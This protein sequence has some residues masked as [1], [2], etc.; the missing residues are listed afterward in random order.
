MSLFTRIVRDRP[1]A[2]FAVLAC[3]LGWSIY[4][5]SWFGAGSNPDNMP[6]GPAMAAFIV[7][8]VQGREALRGWWHRIRN[9]RAAPGWYAVAFLAPAVLHV[10]NVLV[11][12]AFGAPLPTAAQL[13]AWPDVVTG[14]VLMIIAVGIGEEAGWT[15]FAAPMLMRR[16]GI[17]GAWALLSAVRIAWHL[18]LMLSGDLPWLM[19]IVGNAAFQMVLL[20]L[21]RGGGRWSLAAVWHASLNAFGGVFLFPMVTG[22][23]NERLGIL[24]V[25]E[26]VVLAVVWLSLERRRR[27]WRADF[28]PEPE[29]VG[30]SAPITVAA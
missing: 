3:L 13:S 21:V 11:N 6:L 4:I 2:S 26:Y 23:D 19:G 9:W 25:V 18:P 14:F 30:G 8:S 16:H 29:S 17:Y 15:A 12:H 20:L 27:G 1:F 24:L 5:A 10:V 22:A 7:A 28:W